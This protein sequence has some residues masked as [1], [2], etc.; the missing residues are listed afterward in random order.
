MTKGQTHYNQQ[1]T[2]GTIKLLDQIIKV[3]KLSRPKQIE[4]LVEDYWKIVQD[5]KQ[6]NQ[7][8]ETLNKMKVR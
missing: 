7:A 5:S 8:K 6:V 1:I 4:M 2:K 3:T